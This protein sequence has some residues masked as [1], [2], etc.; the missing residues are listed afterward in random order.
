MELLR[1]MRSIVPRVRRPVNRARSEAGETPV[2]NATALQAEW[3]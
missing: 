2:L 3:E 1:A